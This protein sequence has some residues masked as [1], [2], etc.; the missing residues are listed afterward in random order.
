MKFIRC[1][2]MQQHCFGYNGW[3]PEF[4]GLSNILKIESMA[5]VKDFYKRD[6]ELAERI[7]NYKT[8]NSDHLAQIAMNNRNIAEL[9]L[10][11]LNL[12]YSFDMD[13]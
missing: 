12:Q 9:E 5:K 11:R 2:G 10:Q 4:I 1:N 7:A 13:K 8:N 6:M 3:Q